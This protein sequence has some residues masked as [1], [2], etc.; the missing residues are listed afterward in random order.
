MS[1]A[2]ALRYFFREAMS[3]L[4]RGWRVG[5]LAI[6]TIA[7]SLMLGG[8]FLVASRNLEESVESWR[9]QLRVVFYLRAGSDASD[10]TRLAGELRAAPWG[11]S[12]ERGTAA[13]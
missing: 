7:V 4:L 13:G 2:R 3:N 11:P 8:T 5:A 12:V 9:G 10:L 1:L 6:L